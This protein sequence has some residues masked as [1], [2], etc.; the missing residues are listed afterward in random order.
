MKYKAFKYLITL[1]ILAISLGSCKKEKSFWDD[2]FVAP[3]AHGGLSLS[4]LFPDTVIKSNPDSTLK[5]GFE[6]T[7]INYQLDSL[8]KIPD[9]TVTTAFTFTVPVVVPLTAGMNIPLLNNDPNNSDTYYNLPNGIQLKKAIIKQ[10]GISYT[11]QNSVYRPLAYHYRLLSATKN[12]VPF[13]TIFYINGADSASGTL[14]TISGFIDLSGYTL[15]F[16][17]YHH[18]KFNTTYEIDSVHIDNNAAPG[19]YLHP[20]QGI[21][22]KFSFSSMVPQY[23][24]GYFGNQTIS[25][26]PDTTVFDIFKTIKSG[27]L[28]LNS[29]EIKLKIENGFGVTMRANIGNLTAISAANNTVVPINP[30][31]STPL[32]TPINVNAAINTGTGAT[33]STKTLTLNNTNSSTLTSFI[34]ILPDKIAYALNAQLNPYGN[35][36]LSNDFGYYG[37][38][39][40]AYMDADIPLYFSA[41]NIALG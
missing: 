38:A 16:T 34:G 7:L 27:M 25:V 30:S 13:D 19:G 11:M 15:D 1:F 8:L 41:S 29:A 32:S 22:S 35:Q 24:L 36:S 12:N 28:N 4:S 21:T 20:N 33:P 26:G 5:I 17:G 6:T 39:F 31:N 23:A 18:N 40:K 9:T 37:T 2:N 14:G 10:G 3:I